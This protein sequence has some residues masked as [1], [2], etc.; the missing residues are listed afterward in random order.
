MWKS[1]VWDLIDEVLVSYHLGRESACN[2]DM[3]PLGCT[4]DKVK[5]TVDKARAN[6]VLVRSNTVLATFN[7]NG[8]DS[9][10]EDL[11]ALQPSIVN[12]LPVNLFD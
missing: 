2:K 4:Y 3:F 9:I 1:D 8:L 6:N 7:I 5:K 12:F 10:L 11:V